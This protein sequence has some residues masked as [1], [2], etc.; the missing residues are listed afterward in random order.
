MSSKNRKKWKLT[1][2]PPV[3]NIQKT[4][5]QIKPQEEILPQEVNNRFP[6][7]G[8]EEESYRVDWLGTFE[9]ASDLGLSQDKDSESE[10]K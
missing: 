10:Q 1:N 8:D 7:I 3:N 6:E 2:T 4:I 9:A 5:L